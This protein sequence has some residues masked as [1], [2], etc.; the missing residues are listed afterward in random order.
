MKQSLSKA[1]VLQP[2]KFDFVLSIIIFSIFISSILALYAAV[3]LVPSYLSPDTVIIKQIAFFLAG[4][5]VIASIMYFGNE[6]LFTLVRLGYFI[7]LGALVYL[8]ISAM[9]VRFNIQALSFA[10]PINGAVSWF[11]FPLIGTFQPSEFMKVILVLLVATIIHD[12]NEN[13]SEDSFESDIHL[14]RK[15][16][17]WASL[18]LLLILFQPDTGIFL[19]IVASLS[20]MI[21]CS[22]IRKE[23]IIAI[24]ILLFGLLL[25]FVVAFYFFPNS[26]NDFFTDGQ[27]YKVGRIY[28]WLYP[29]ESAKKEGM[30]LYNSL[31]GM[32]SAGF[33][34]YPIGSSVIDIP[35][36]HTDFIFSVIGIYYG[37]M[38][39]S[40]ILILCF[41]L[42]ARLFTIARRSKNTRDKLILI[43]FISI[44]VVQQVEN[45]GMTIGLFPITGITLPLISA[46]GSSLLSY[47]IMIG[48]AMNISLRA[49]KL[50]DFVYE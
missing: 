48:M 29:E 50:S 21:I 7:L 37:F 15:V 22:G 42:N 6:N 14:F 34:G 46:G 26:F 36:A 33:Q 10:K 20:M 25:I 11:Q 43:G 40:I 24:A 16:L 39:T 5:A 38:G 19:I 47:M 49:K 31:L 4:V 8:F 9:L 41:A 45:I 17:T 1:R 18:P 13:K 32:G 28:G 12:H 27:D 44:L 3:P 35:E 2:Q 30:Q 23:W